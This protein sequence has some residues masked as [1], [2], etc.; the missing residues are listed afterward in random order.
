MVAMANCLSQSADVT[1]YG[2]VCDI[3]DYCELEFETIDE[4]VL[5]LVND[6][7][8]MWLSEQTLRNI[9]ID[10]NLLEEV[11]DCEMVIEEGQLLECKQCGKSYDNLDYL[12]FH[13]LNG[14]SGTFTGKQFKVG[15]EFL[16][17]N[18]YVLEEQDEDVLVVEHNRL[19]SIGKHWEVIESDDEFD[20]YPEEN[21]NSNYH[22]ENNFEFNNEGCEKKNVEV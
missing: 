8:E 10:G 2:M 9:K 18:G 6:H 12:L 21:A 16:H 7:D 1:I 5:H 17:N 19:N 13:I 3:S 11:K 14:H 20:Y 22:G 15:A 4:L